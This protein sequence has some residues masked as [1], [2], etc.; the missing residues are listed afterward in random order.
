MASASAEGPGA[1]R[2]QPCR[3]EF[4]ADR[5]DAERIRLVS[6]APGRSRT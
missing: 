4:N 1:Y 5:R 2:I 3:I 6:H